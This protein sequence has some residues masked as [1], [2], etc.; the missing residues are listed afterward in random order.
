VQNRDAIE[1]VHEKQTKKKIK[2][3]YTENQYCQKKT[4]VVTE[5]NR[6]YKNDGCVCP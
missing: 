5:I 3:P 1:C 4:K 2:R 6:D